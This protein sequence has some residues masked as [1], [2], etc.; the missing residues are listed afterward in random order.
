MRLRLVLY[1]IVAGGVSNVACTDNSEP[2]APHSD[3]TTRYLLE[4]QL[5]FVTWAPP[6]PPLDEL[7]VQFTVVKGKKCDLVIRLRD[8]EQDEEENEGGVEHRDNGGCGDA[9]A[10]ATKGRPTEGRFF[11]RIRL[12]AGTLHRHGN[13]RLIKYGEA[14]EIRLKVDPVRLM[15]SFSPHLEFNPSEPGEMEL[16]YEAA[17]FEFVSRESEIGLWRQEDP[18]DPWE[19]VESAR[20][21]AQ[22]EIRAKADLGGFT[23]YA[24]AI[25]R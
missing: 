6:G 9:T 20:V 21:E 25:G 1:L 23:R 7:E 2:L 10:S 11:F 3:F 22:D 8:E 24:L 15:V 19:R 14:V 16:R 4:S 13:G 5:R 12:N 17:A 18:G